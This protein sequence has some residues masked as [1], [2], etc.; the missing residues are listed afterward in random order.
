MSGIPAEDRRARTWRL[1]AIELPLV[2]ALGSI[3]LIVGAYINN[4]YLAG[5]TMRG[6]LL[7]AIVVAAYAIVS[8]LAVVFFLRR[9]Q[10]RDLTVLTFAGDLVVWTFVIY[11]TGAEASWLFFIPLLRV[12]DQTQTTFRRALAFALFGTFCFAAMLGWVVA[13]DRRPVAPAAGI[14]KTVFILMSGIYISLAARTAEARRERLKEAIRMSRDA[15]ARAEEASAAKSEFVANMSHEMRTPLQ[16]VIGMLQL[17]IDDEPSGARVRRLSM[18]RHSAEMLLALIDDVLDFARIEARR[19]ELQPVS[20]PIRRM[21]DDT[22]KALGVMAASKQLTLSYIVRP[23]VPEMVWG[24]PVRLRQIL[25]NLVGNS[26]KFTKQGE[27]SVQVSR[28]ADAIRFDVCDTG[29]GIP[30]AVRQR[31]F[32]PFMQADTSHARRHGGAGLGLAIVARLVEAMGGTVEVKSEQGTGSIF[33]ITIPEQSGGQAIPPVQKPWEHALAGQLVAIVEPAVM[34]R[35]T[36][37]HVLR[38]RGMFASAFATADEVHAGRFACAVTS[39][40]RIA[41]KPQVVITSPLDQK[42]YPVQVSWPVSERELVDAVGQAL[43]LVTV[44]AEQPRD[45]PLHAVRSLR[46]LLV[47][48]NEVNREVVSEMLGRLGHQVTLASDGESAIARLEGGKF[49]AV[50]MDV[51]LPGIDGL[52]VTRRFRD[53]GGMTPVIGLTAHSSRESRDRCLIAG[54]KSVLTKPVDSAQLAAALRSVTEIDDAL[55]EVAG[56][57]PAILER[58]RDAFARQTPE[59]LSAIRDGFARGDGAAVAHHVHTLKGSLSHFTW[60]R[61]AELA[62]E[63]ESAAARGDLV[64]AAALMPD[65]E[66]AVAELYAALMR[67]G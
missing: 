17:A 25:I 67:V 47:E 5:A 28:A 49:D 13:V 39:D 29:I 34:A 26:V 14:V 51:Q 35:T 45:V 31:I 55:L 32:Q 22:M 53:G 33:T 40:P 1:A 10:P 20:F 44:S 64:G 24:D 23:D 57:S 4:R 43:G 8:W 21:V 42:E 9:D 56:G 11:Q 46:I 36:I 41:V 61:G 65:L 18:A 59:I 58:V 19:L 62:R 60:N 38:A 3:L 27:I 66:T 63:L 2:R 48:D 52:E 54:M 12:A 16:G 50:F 30:L 15:H 6:W 37:A 7:A